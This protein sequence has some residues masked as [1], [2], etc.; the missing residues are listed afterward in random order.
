[1]LGG[2]SA[3]TTLAG[4]GLQHQDG[5]SHLLAYALPNLK[6]YDPAYA[7]E[8]AVI[9][10]DGLRRMYEQQ[11]N[12]F[13]YLTL[14]NEN[15]A[16]PP[17]P[18]VEGIEEGILNG[19]YKFKAA[20]NPNGKLH[21][22]LFGSGAI[23]NEVLKAQALLAEKYQVAADVWSVTSYKEL[24]RDGHERDRWNL[25]HPEETHKLPYVTRCIMNS[26][27]VCV[28]ASDYMK[29]LPDT[30]SR[31]L[32]R[33]FVSLGTDGFGRSESR[34]ALRDFFEVD[35]RFITLATLAVLAREKQIEPDVV[36][37]AMREMEID[38]SKVDSGEAPGR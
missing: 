16:H 19:M 1:M 17:I 6:A 33:P 37:K 28:A 29:A 27:G 24:Y 7:F 13:Y 31:W 35:A 12:I 22:Q 38:P 20:E 3:R 11:E 14:M 25:L 26:P 34:A 30:I 23:L 4:E 18:K 5:H 32:H 10:R 21:A 2:T 9:V 15:Y 8:L 36:A